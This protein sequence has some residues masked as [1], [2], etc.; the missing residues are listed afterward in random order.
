MNRRAFVL[1]A[2]AA[3]A[4]PR[5]AAAAS[6]PKV[7]ATFSVLGD[8]VQ[9][10]AG[11]RVALTVLVGPDGDTEAYEATA[12]DAR[13]VADAD[14]LVTNGLNPEFEPWLPDL[15]ARSQFHGARVAASDGV[16][17]LKKAEEGN[18]RAGAAPAEIDQ[19]A[20]HDAANGAVYAANIAQA[21]ARVDP[22]HGPEYRT[23]GEAYQAELLAL[24]GWARQRVAT[25]P[26]AK[27]RVISSH[28][29]FAYLARA[30][31]IAMT[32]ARG[33]T[34]DKEPTAAQVAQLIR[35][36]RQDKIRAM[37]I[38]NMSDPRLIQR[39]AGETGVELGGKLY[40]DALA[41]PGEDGDTYVRMVRHN[42]E[43][44][45]AG[46]MRN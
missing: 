3:P 9:Q 12:A 39:I 46:M 10:V 21:L 17:T 26:A 22:A 16:R 41:R 2:L 36:I 42:I 34:N 25:V 13:A 20:W 28:D 33:W 1:A 27:R 30:Y 14:L 31:G 4:L 23:R 24:D 19:H 40:S 7:V 29:G 5:I 38:E 6:P 15:T 8:M 35:Q 44:L 45:C 11:D 18:G 37:F 32:G 43:T